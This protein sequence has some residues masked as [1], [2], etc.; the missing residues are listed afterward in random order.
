MENLNV[1][2]VAA[3]MGDRIHFVARSRIEAV[4]A[5]EVAW[6]LGGGGHPTAASATIHSRNL[7][8]LK[9]RLKKIL[10]RI[11]PPPLRARNIMTTPVKSLSVRST[12]AEAKEYQRRSGL[13]RQHFRRDRKRKQHVFCGVKTKKAP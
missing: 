9:A 11:V 1:L 13:R 3:R 4:D 6:E 12:L 2:F 5:G 7:S 10:R 8:A